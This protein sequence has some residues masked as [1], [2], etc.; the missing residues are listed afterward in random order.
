V[1]PLSGF[2]ISG[3]IF[4]AIKDASYSEKTCIN[5]GWNCFQGPEYMILKHL[6]IH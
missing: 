1:I 2:S 5:N 6:S 4:E 3:N